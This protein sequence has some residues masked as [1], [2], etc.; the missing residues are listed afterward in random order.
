MVLDGTMGKSGSL[1]GPGFQ[2]TSD[3]GRQVGGNLFHSFSSFNIAADESAIFSGPASVYNVIARVTGGGQSYIDGLLRSTIPG[4]DLYLINPAGVMFGRSASLDI[5]GSFHVTTADYLSL[6]DG[7]RFDAKAQVN[8][9]LTVAD[10]SGFGFLG[11][12]PA[13]VRF[14]GSLIEVPEGKTISV[15]GGDINMTNAYLF[16]PSGTVKLVSTASSGMV[17]LAT[18]DTSSFQKLGTIR[19]EH[20]SDIIKQTG[21]VTLNDIEVSGTKG[22]SIYI[23]GGEFVLDHAIVGGDTGGSADGGDIDIR[24]RGDLNSINSAWISSGTIGDGSSGNIFIEAGSFSL[25]DGSQIFT[26]TVSGGAAGSITIRAGESIIISGYDRSPSAIGSESLG[27][28]DAGD[29][30]ITAGTLSLSDFGTIAANSEGTG[31][32][33]NIVITAGNISISTDPVLA[34]A[35]GYRSGISSTAR[36][37]AGDIFLVTGNFVMD[38]GEINSGAAGLG[39]GGDIS[40]SSSGD[41]SLSGSS[42]I[43]STSAVDSS[44]GAIVIKGRT[45]TM[46]DGS[47]VMTSTVGA[48]RGGEIGI[49]LEGSLSMTGGEKSPY[50]SS[51]ALSGVAGD[52]NISAGSLAM[53]GGSE[54]SAD[55]MDGIAGDVTVLIKGDAF[56]SGNR[57]TADGFLPTA[58]MSNARGTGDAGTV[59]VRAGSLDL[60]DGAIISSISDTGNAGDIAITSDR[61]VTLSYI[62]DT[63]LSSGYAGGIYSDSIAGNAGNVSIDAGFL[64]LAGHVRISTTTSGN[65]DARGGDISIVSGALTMKDACQIFADAIDGTAGNITV[66]IHGL[67]SLSGYDSSGDSFIPTAIMSNARGS[68]NAGTI[69]IETENMDVLDGSKVVTFSNT[70]N[71]GSISISADGAVNL[72]SPLLGGIS[73]DSVSGNAG[74]ISINSL[75]LSL[76]GAAWITSSSYGA[77]NAGK[78]DISAA[79]SVHISGYALSGSTA[80]PSGIYGFAAGDGSGGDIRIRADKLIMESGNGIV[81]SSLGRGDGGNI[82]VAAR[83]IILLGGSQIVTVSRGAGDAGNINVDTSAG[84]RISG[85]F[86]NPDGSSYKSGINSAS[87]GTG[88]GGNITVHSSSIS[89]SDEGIINARSLGSGNAGSINITAT[90][91]VFLSDASITTAADR[92]SGGVITFSG[93]DVILTGGSRITASVKIG[94]GGGGNVNM[95][96]ESFVALDQSS[97]TAQADQGFG[98]SIL[99]TSDVVLLSG[100]AFFSASSNVEG[101]EGKVEVNAPNVDI[102]GSLIILPSSFIDADALM[103]SICA[104]R[105]AASSFLVRTLEGL[106]LEP[107]TLTPVF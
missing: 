19:I 70:G 49:T 29:I 66:T 90:D 28:G 79:D 37:N 81:A 86:L 43:S 48:G 67:T 14:S 52:I 56:L 58:I 59:T 25:T 100:D 24:L 21:L 31:M 63:A 69:A 83:E 53:K 13:P 57:L 72:S 10:P 36:N 9:V 27:A 80:I 87:Y 32:G 35:I 75:S 105:G 78:I 99:L 38:Y 77:G 7:G 6:S 50:I 61:G 18:L 51:V 104:E 40:I 39:K 103:P 26:K 102:S 82:S 41:I 17:P 84:I 76:A 54:I 42:S 94:E 74:N 96:S 8:D 33:G 91:G 5:Q 93:G 55:T 45:M 2:I 23:R 3:L 98:G 88:L 85:K 92:A 71:A 46:T 106:P 22:G 95:N 64:S 34:E 60:A 62:S 65:R 97:V 20:S 101:R 107:G 89:L 4:A 12:N 73:S 44:A 47:S 1:S 16:A 30:S 68:G 11:G 15:T